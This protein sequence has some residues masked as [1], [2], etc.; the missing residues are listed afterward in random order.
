MSSEV[1]ERIRKNPKFTEL[2]RKR[3][4][5]AWTLSAIVMVIFFGLFLTVSF[6]PAVLAVRI[7]SGYVTAGL[8]F[9][10]FIFIFSWILT[11]VYVRRA[12][13][14]FDALTEEIVRESWKEK[15]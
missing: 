7:G 2:V 14:E 13:T 4:S 6:N 11:A 3:E 9:G 5:F 10:L 1:Y 15:K 8:A 12:N